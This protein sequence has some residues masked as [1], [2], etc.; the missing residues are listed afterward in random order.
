VYSTVDGNWADW[1]E[2]Q[3]FLPAIAIARH[4]EKVK[5]RK[6]VRACFPGSVDSFRIHKGQQRVGPCQS[7]TGIS[8]IISVRRC[9]TV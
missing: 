3:R 1:S 8:H 2:P 9:T 5:R 7:P 4:A 6:H